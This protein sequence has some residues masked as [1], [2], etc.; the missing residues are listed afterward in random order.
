MAYE[1]NDWSCGEAITTEKLQHME[2]GIFEAQ[3]EYQCSVSQRTLTEETVVTEAEPDEPVIGTLSYQGFIDSD[4]LE[5][6]FNGVVYECTRRQWADSTALYSEYGAGDA[7]WDEYPFTVISSDLT[8]T[9]KLYTELPGTYTIKLKAIDHSAT[10]SDCFERAVKKVTHAS[11]QCVKVRRYYADSE[12]NYEVG[13][14]YAQLFTL[15]THDA[16]SIPQGGYGRVT[17]RYSGTADDAR[18][19][20]S[21]IRYIESQNAVYHVPPITS[22]WSFMSDGRPVCEL[23]LFARDG[24]ISIPANTI[25]VGVVAFFTPYKESVCLI[26]GDCCEEDIPEPV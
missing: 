8:G 13:F 21:I 15:D 20:F 12:K 19:A 4:T 9:N 6:T 17:I 22:F 10:T 14:Q 11:G 5:V 25:N 2:A 1:M 7:E 26:E 18:F 16:I 3:N 24:A 23:E